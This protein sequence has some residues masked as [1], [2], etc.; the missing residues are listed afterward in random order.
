[1]AA[2]EKAA[3][4]LVTSATAHTTD[5]TTNLTAQNTLA[6]HESLRREVHGP[7][8]CCQAPATVLRR[9]IAG[10]RVQLRAYC[11]RCWHCGRALPQVALR[12]SG[13]DI[14]T[15][16]EADLEL[17]ERAQHSAASAHRAEG[18]RQ[19]RLI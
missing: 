6:L 15:L 18:E 9:K 14:D 5:C 2:Q 17:I 3:G 10:G 1:M 8:G 19:C 13:I 12:E 11:T 16:P 7:T 4:M